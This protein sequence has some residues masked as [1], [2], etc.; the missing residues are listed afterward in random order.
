MST[1]NIE[2]T[3]SPYCSTSF[4]RQR[5]VFICARQ[6]ANVP[7][8]LIGSQCDS[9]RELLEDDLFLYFD[10]RN[11]PDSSIDNVLAMFFNRGRSL[12]SNGVLFQ[13]KD[14]VYYVNKGCL[15]EV[16]VSGYNS[17]SSF[18]NDSRIID[19]I[20]ESLNGY[21]EGYISDIGSG[22]VILTPLIV[23]TIENRYFKFFTKSNKFRSDCDI[24]REEFSDLIS[25]DHLTAFVNPLIE[26]K[27][28]V[29]QDVY[30]KL[31]SIVKEID[32]NNIRVI[33]TSYYMPKQGVPFSGSNFYSDE[34]KQETLLYLQKR[35]LRHGLN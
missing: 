21:S 11:G 15:F 34:I 8:F 22:S 23:I 4:Q 9:D 35:L 13:Y 30:R 14:K 17:H 18:N 7:L 27:K 2:I 32:D 28:G 16:N 12:A 10:P 26:D 19:N 33:N 24:N 3:H 29:Y 5:N 1:V 20:Q 6:V 25:N 31:S